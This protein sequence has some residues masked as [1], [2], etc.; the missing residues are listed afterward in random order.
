MIKTNSTLSVG[1]KCSKLLS[2]PLY[3]NT[4]MSAIVSWRVTTLRWCALSPGCLLHSQ[5]PSPPHP[6]PPYS[7]QPPPPLPTPAWTGRQQQPLTM[8]TSS[9]SPTSSRRKC[10]RRLICQQKSPQGRMSFCLCLN[11]GE[12]AEDTGK[13]MHQF[14]MRG[15]YSD[16]FTSGFQRRTNGQMGNK[17][18]IKEWVH[19]GCRVFKDFVL[20]LNSLSQ[21]YPW[22]VTAIPYTS[23]PGP[24]FTD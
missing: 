5:S 18:Q 13:M 22:G 4:T 14:L 21:I 12:T 10:A 2:L 15:S 9:P 19:A 16:R 8:A 23:G 17:T 7:L 6:L 20:C 24:W 1:D 11:I 3:R